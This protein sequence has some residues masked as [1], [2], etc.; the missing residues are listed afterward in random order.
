MHAEVAAEVA[1]FELETRSTVPK[2]PTVFDGDA[3][4]T[5]H[6]A[7]EGR[8]GDSTASPQAPSSA[9]RAQSSVAST[10]RSSNASC[11]KP[12]STDMDPGCPSRADADG[13]GDLAQLRG[14][15]DARTATPPPRNA[16]RPARS[17][18]STIM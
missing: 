18:Q 1:E 9:A 14:M 11:S 12:S 7:T 6:E 13:I 2:S 16:H 8:L 17:R 10:A 4:A 3:L 5:L 15:S